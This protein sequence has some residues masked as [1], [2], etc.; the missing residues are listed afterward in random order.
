MTENVN[1]RRVCLEALVLVM[2]DKKFLNEV[3]RDTLLKYQY[4][5]KNKRSYISRM[6]RGTVERYI[7][8]DACISSYS[9]A[10]I[11]KLNP[12]IR[13]ILRLAVYEIRYMDSIPESATC[14]EYVKLA[15][16]KAPARLSG[17]VNGI[18]RSMI[19]SGFDKVHLTENE[20]Y[21]MPKWLY[22]KFEEEYGNASY[23]CRAFLDDNVLTIRTNLA[24][25]EPDE[26]RDKL[27]SQ[28]VKVMP[29]CASDISDADGNKENVSLDIAF[30]IE[31]VDYIESLTAFKEGLFYVQD[32]SSMMVGLKAD[33]KAGNIVVDVCAAP[34]GKSIH[35]AQLLTRCERDSYNGKKGHV[36]SYDISENKVA[37]IR[38]NITRSGLDNISAEVFDARVSNP[39]MISKADIVIADLP[40]S[41]LG[42]IGKKPDI[43]SRVKIEDIL[44]LSELQLEILNVCKD[45][46]KDG[47]TLMYSTCTVSK[48]ENVDN[49]KRFLESNK[50]F[51]LVEERQYMP[52]K[53]QDGFYIA[54]L[55]KLCA[56]VLADI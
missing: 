55:E 29:V 14:N 40:C 32:I 54:K 10:K 3:L 53:L 43:K 28:G 51:R 2:E 20:V 11:N 6:L 56:K 31:N 8:L 27:E 52:S 42:V 1:V 41:G 47:G 4:L 23:I 37:L 34:G 16:K 25:C 13:N 33:V 15:K 21:S 17:F 18:L 48:A 44:E 12:Y 45:Y 19:R 26:L 22:D 30:A 38:E 36:Y 24:K 39:N 46:V 9:S 5:E 49:V 7:E 35:A 50:E